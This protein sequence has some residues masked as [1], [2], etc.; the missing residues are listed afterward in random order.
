MTTSTGGSY[1]GL[2]FGPGTAYMVTGISGLDDLP[3]V[4]G[5]D[6]GKPADDGDYSG[7]DY[8][9][10][11]TVTVDFGIIGDSPDDYLIKR[12]AFA[13]AFTVGRA[14]S[15][16]LVKDST[17]LVMAKVRKRAVPYV[18]AY[19][20]SAT[21]AAVEFYCAD[22]RLYD[23][24]VSSATLALDVTT[25]GREYDLTFP[26]AY[27]TALT[28]TGAQVSNIGNVAARPVVRF[29]G[30]VTSPG[31]ENLTTGERFDLALTVESGEYVD[32]DMDA[33][34]VLLNGTASRRSTVRT[35]SRWLTLL[36]GVNTLALRA[37]AYDASSLA[38]VTFRST[39][40]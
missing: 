9:G 23:A 34:T 22:P 6:L 14:P 12:D 37:T 8:T 3:A 40:L 7:A 13:A 5:A 38:T 39:W 32:V 2:A 20:A 10:P 29:L 11:R 1:N 18:A 28:P 4:R 19:H 36:P 27:G 35:G 17:R 25:G 15:A 26:L 33:R 30:P 31:I 24:V 21:P 16:L